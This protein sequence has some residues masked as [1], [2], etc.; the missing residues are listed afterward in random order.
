MKK[1]LPLAGKFILLFAIILVT[2][3]SVNSQNYS[4][5]IE[6]LD[7]VE[8]ENAEKIIFTNNELQHVKTGFPI[9]FNEKEYGYIFVS[10]EGWLSFDENISIEELA[11]KGQVNS[12]IS[13]LL[14]INKYEA[15]E[16][17]N[18]SIKRNNDNIIVQWENADFAFQAH[19]LEDGKIEFKYNIDLNDITNRKLK[20]NKAY[21]L[22]IVNNNFTTGHF[23]FSIINKKAQQ[24]ETSFLKEQNSIIFTIE[25]KNTKARA[26]VLTAG[27]GSEPATIS[28][29][30]DTQGEATLNFDFTLESNGGQRCTFTDVFIDQPAGNEI[31]D[32]TTVI[33]GAILTTGAEVETGVITN[34]RITFSS[35]P[36]GVGRL[37]D[38]VTRT[39]T[40]KIWLVAEGGLPGTAYNKHLVF[41]VRDESFTMSQGSV[42]NANIQSGDANNEIVGACVVQSIPYFEGFESITADNTLPTCM[43]ATDLGTDVYTYTSDQGTYNRV[44][45]TGTDFASVQYGSDD[46]LFTQ[47]LALTNGITYDF[48]MYYITDGGAGHD[49]E[50]M[51]GNAQNSGAMTGTVIGA[52]LTDPTNTSYQELTGTF[53]VPSTGTYYVGIHVTSNFTPWY[54]SF[55]D[56]NIT[57][58]IPGEVTIS[59]GSN[60]E[61]SAIPSII[62]TQG[63]ALINF[64]FSVDDPGTDG[65]PV[66]INEIIIQQGTGNDVA[67]WS[68]AIAGALLTDGT[69]TQ[70]ADITINTDNITITNIDFSGGG[71]NLGEVDNGTS[72]EYTLKVWLNCPTIG[73]NEG[74]NF[75]FEVT[76]TDFSVEASSSSFAFGESA[77]TNT[78]DNELTVTATE[79]QFVTNEPPAN[80][81][82]TT[83]FTVT[84]NATDECGNIDTDNTCSVTLA[85]NSGTG[86][87]S[88]STGLTQ[89]LSSGTY[90]WSD[91]Q[92][93]TEETFRLQVTGNGGCSGLTQATS[94]DINCS[95]IV[96]SC[97]N[98]D[99]GNANG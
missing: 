50:V 41:R 52:T 95:T 12:F 88:S 35:V 27:A 89:S 75:V 28:E 9:L 48:S 91:V 18:V 49:L 94:I 74:D 78:N 47:P 76:N 93:D 65:N 57:G 4:H 36:N 45:R 37:N 86:T 13:P 80:V 5:K 30:I 19:L 55:D 97:D 15:T 67:D 8:I 99:D 68:T 43:A 85:L 58:Q 29:I 72:K 22:G 98:W 61:V 92:Y 42:N 20:N 3:T 69:S 16:T 2:Q 64:D 54:L 83:D 56:I 60:N 1:L 79:L 25:D 90:T 63:E 38:G 11:G 23:P 7:Y 84:V 46:W 66:E 17:Y 70:T 62:D 31:A 51:F 14:F 44:A 73:A 71:N 24:I 87:V 82:L 6:G 39:Y 32:W 40:L 96:L 33:Q 10:N 59:A 81:A 53:T 26:L 77:N 34:N 21:L